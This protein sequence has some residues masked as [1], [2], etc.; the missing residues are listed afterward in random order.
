VRRG[1]AQAA[2]RAGRDAQPVGER[3]P[4]VLQLVDEETRRVELAHVGQEGEPPLDLEGAAVEIGAFDDVE[5]L[6]GVPRGERVGHEPVEILALRAGDAPDVDAVGPALRA[7]LLA[8]GEDG[9]GV[10]G[11][12]QRGGELGEVGADAAAAGLRGEF[13]ADQRDVHAAAPGGRTAWIRRVQ[14]SQWSSST[15]PTPQP[16]S[17]LRMAGGRGARS[18]RMVSG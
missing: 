11:G 12:H 16:S 7:R 9:D 6:L 4:P 15:A 13:V 18:M 17:R 14:R 3:R 5:R 8:A 2:E 10:S 1:E